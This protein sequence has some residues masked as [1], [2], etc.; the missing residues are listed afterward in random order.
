MQHIHNLSTSLI[1]L[2]WLLSAFFYSVFLHF[3]H[4][5]PAFYKNKN[6][7]GC[8]F[9]FLWQS[10]LVIWVFSQI[11]VS[12]ECMDWDVVLTPSLQAWCVF[13]LFM[14]L[15]SQ[16]MCFLRSLWP[17]CSLL[18][19]SCLSLLLFFSLAFSNLIHSWYVHSAC[20]CQGKVDKKQSATTR[21]LQ[22]K[23]LTLINCIRGI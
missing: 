18:S 3:H 1:S 5:I 11:L 19:Y 16:Y 15:L 2:M 12:R 13:S 7:Y 10:R 14:S 23:R 20:L 22:E 21:L 9:N 17:R 8:C 4:S 6:R